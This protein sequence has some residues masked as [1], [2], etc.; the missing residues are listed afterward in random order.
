MPNHVEVK[1]AAPKEVI[2][3]LWNEE[4]KRI[5]FEKIL[6]TPPELMNYTAGPLTTEENQQKQIEKYGV[7]NGECLIGQ[8]AKDEIRFA[9]KYGASNWYEWRTTNWGTKWNAYNSYKETDKI[10]HFTT[11]WCPPTGVIE[12]WS[13]EFP[14]EEIIV[15]WEEEQG[16]GEIYAVKNG[17]RIATLKEWDVPHLSI[18]ET[19]KYFQIVE[20][21]DD[22][23]GPN[24][25]YETGKFYIDW[26]SDHCY[27]NVEEARKQ[28]DKSIR[29]RLGIKKS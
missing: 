25:Q 10:V 2:D 13:R 18:V 26:E 12:A 24:V 15:T 28:I 22:N 6:P 1:I 23:G 17:E 7:E 8:T 11:A 3:F 4:E 14:E 19:Y 27:D 20:C 29:H 5:D 21:M 16:F 9:E